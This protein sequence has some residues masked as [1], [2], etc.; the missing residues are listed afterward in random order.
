MR[1]VR[2]PQSPLQAEGS[3]RTRFKVCVLCRAAR[4]AYGPTGVSRHLLSLLSLLSWLY[5]DSTIALTG[6][7]ARR[8]AMFVD[9]RREQIQ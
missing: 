9:G 4:C 1:R 5:L 7:C 6:R 2:R 3:G 8:D